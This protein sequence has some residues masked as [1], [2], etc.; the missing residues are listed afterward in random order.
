MGVGRY[1]QFVLGTCSSEDWLVDYRAFTSGK[2]DPLADVQ[3][4]W[5]RSVLLMIPLMSLPTL[6]CF[7]AEC[8]V[9]AFLVWCGLNN[10]LSTV[11][12]VA[13]LSILQFMIFTPGHDS[14]HGS[15]SSNSFINGL[16]GRLSFEFMG[17]IAVFA[18]W[19]FLHLQH[20]K[21][22]NHPDRD[23]DKYACGGPTFLLPLRWFTTIAQYVVFLLN[24][25]DGG[26]VTLAE[27][28]ECVVDLTLNL[29]V[30]VL[31]YDFGC[32]YQVYYY[33]ILPSFFCHGLLVFFFDFLPHYRHHTTPVEDRYQTTS[34]IETYSFLEPL[35][36]AF[37]H[38]QNYHMIH[39]LHP[40]IPF[41]RYKAKWNSRVEELKERGCPKL[42]WK[43]SK[44]NDWKTTKKE[45]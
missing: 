32:F 24:S 45:E 18:G 11:T 13:L 30:C 31:S 29:L 38:Y 17:P 37:L 26:E 6:L 40:K 9:Y 16:V 3:S 39:H 36:T 1:L 14:A 8:I 2:E 44:Q 43:L 5:L 25:L 35:L 34:N 4:P 7:A 21:F 12:L 41:Y 42:I 15:V 27:K 20:H 23:P 19:R 22:T 33:W 28:V 10:V